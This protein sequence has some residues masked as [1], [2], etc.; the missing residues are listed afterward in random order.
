M[1][2]PRSWPTGS[3]HT[4]AA[5]CATAH[6]GQTVT[7]NG[8]VNTYRT[9][10]DQVFVDLRDRYGLTQVVFESDDAEL[11]K[12]VANELGRECRPQ[13]HAA[14]SPPAAGQGEPE[15][16]H[17]QDR[18]RGRGRRASSTAA[19][20]RRS[21]SRSSRRRSW[22]TR[23][24]ASSTAT[25]TCGGRRFRTRSLLRHRLYKVIRDYLDG[26]GFLEVETPLLG[27]STP[28]GAR[29]YLVPEP[30]VSTAQWYALPQSP[31][32]LQAAADG[33]RATTSTSRSPGACATRTRGPTASRSSPSSTW[34]CRSSR[35][36]T[37]S[38]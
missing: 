36:T 26:Q 28:E 7:L 12:A 22:P 1:K 5:N 9:Y 34:R 20:R 25:S 23:T 31:A 38:A 35:W 17:R 11:F 2:G 19:R 21:R 14:P 16:R 8:W 24:S 4:P 33:G 27:K 37:F 3:G 30:R 32:A 15:A 18:G 10:N 29:D 6:V 13:R